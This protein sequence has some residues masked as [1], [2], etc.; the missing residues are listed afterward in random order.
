M[1]VALRECVHVAGTIRALALGLVAAVIFGS[2]AAAQEQVLVEFG[3]A[4]SYLANAS[5]PGIGMTWTDPLFPDAGWEAGTFG[6][7]YDEINSAQYLLDTTVPAGTVS[8]FTRTI[9]N[10]A[11]LP[12]VNSLW[13]GSD[14]DDGIAV[15]INGT[16]V[17]RSVEMP[18]TGPLDWD[19][20]AAYSESSNAESPVYAPYHEITTVALP[21]LEQGDNLLAVAVWNASAVSDDLVLVPQLVANKD[22]QLVRGPYLQLGTPTSIR[23]RWRTDIFEDSVVYYGTDP[24]D[25][26]SS[27]TDWTLVLD[28]EL[29]LTDLEPATKYYYAIGNTEEILAGSDPEQY[30][31]TSPPV[32][33]PQ[34]ARIWV[35]GDSGGI[36][37][38]P[39]RDAYEAVTGS[40][41]TDLWLL[42]G[43]N[44]YTSGTDQQYQ[45]FL[46]ELLS[47]ML[48]KTVLWPSI[49]NHDVVP[50]SSPWAQAPY[51]DIFSLPP[52]GEAGGL[53]SGSEAYYSFDFANIHFV[54]LDSQG[55]DRSPP[56][57]GVMLNWL[58]NDLAVTAQEW[59][60]AYWHH[61]PYSDGS[62]KSDTETELIEMRQN[63]VPILESYGV[64]LVLTGHSHT[65]ERSFLIDQHYGDSTTFGAQHVIDGG[66]G[67][68]DEPDGP[69]QKPYGLIPHEGAVYTVAGTGSEIHPG[70]LQYPAMFITGDQLGSLIVEVHGNRLDLSFLDTAQGTLDYF[71]LVKGSYCDG[72]DADA[73][74]VC[75]ADDLCPDDYDPDQADTDGDGTPDACDPCPG[76]ADDDGDGDGL[77]GDVDNCPEDFNPNQ[78]D[79]DVDGIGD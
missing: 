2:P 41:H 8:I 67:R 28:H 17:F 12:S 7:G 26:S 47:D 42:L 75:D 30:F 58:Q 36:G 65:Y 31:V 37:V 51:F 20:P 34:S 64:D 27:V 39:V 49:G 1:T 21:E 38:V 57:G 70:T 40:Q 71:T 32:G 4:T 9:F 18:S 50:L 62:H 78:E 22:L 35:L 10:I 66:S 16:E 24:A 15:W 55:S 5:D 72:P 45:A 13:L 69:Y 25:L 73:D 79:G 44:A 6:I 61:P 56:P 43:D 46:F 3:T 23:I 76:D 14:H 19:T 52:D 60:I 77:C 63:A 59:I 33:T 74:G 11:D 68:A 54:V 29:E 53:S 48:R